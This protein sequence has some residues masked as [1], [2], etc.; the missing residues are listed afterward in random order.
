MNDTTYARIRAISIGTADAR[1]MFGMDHN[2]YTLFGYPVLINASAENTEMAFCAMRGYRLYRR[3]GLSLR[4]ETGG[5][6]L[7]L[8]NVGL[9]V[10]RARYAGL[11]VET[12]GCA[13]MS[14]LMS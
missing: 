4:F 8:A 13:I 14:D 10:C 12:A 6:D 7:A 2:S 11:L 5:K 1:R 3:A 9:V